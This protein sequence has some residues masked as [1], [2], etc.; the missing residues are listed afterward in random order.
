MENVLTGELL[1]FFRGREDIERGIVRHIGSSLEEDPLRVF[2]AARFA[3]RLGFAIAPETAAYARDIDTGALPRE[4]VMGE[5]ALALEA[6]TPSV[7]FEALRDTR[8]MEHWF[9][10][11]KALSGVPQNPAH[12]RGDVWEHTMAVLDLAAGCRERASKP[13]YFMLAALCHDLGKP[14]TTLTDPDGRV[15]APGHAKHGAE[16]AKE[17]LRAITAEKELILYVSN[18]TLLHMLPNKLGGEGSDGDILLML[19]RSVCP[20]DLVLLSFCDARTTL[21]DR[22]FDAVHDRLTRLAARYREMTAAPYA[23]G[24]ELMDLG[25]E[26]GPALGEALRYLRRQQLKGTPRQKAL[27]KTVK[28]YKGTP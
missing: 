16:T 17:F 21:I 18:M 26:P 4:R 12:H 7:F 15:R 23:G 3:A 25:I 11:V 27:A 22:D 14:R 2:R 9:G 24:R 10:P 8:A 1:D 28:K 13:P 20:E 19:D 6:E 5:M